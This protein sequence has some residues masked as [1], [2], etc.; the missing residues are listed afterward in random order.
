MQSNMTTKITDKI[1]FMALM[2]TIT[3]MVTH[4]FHA[5]LIKT[6]YIKCSQFQ[7]VMKFWMGQLITR[8]HCCLDLYISVFC[9]YID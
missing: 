5:E 3:Q 7:S 9:R 6:F 2:I 1:L 8:R 4:K